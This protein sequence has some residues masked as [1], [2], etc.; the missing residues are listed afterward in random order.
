LFSVSDYARR[1]LLFEVG[2]HLFAAD[3]SEVCE[4]LEPAEA[5][6]VPGVVPGIRGLINL[7]GTLLVAGEF[8]TLLGL[9]PGPGDEPALVVFEQAGQRIALE[10]D[11]VVG[12]ASSPDGLLD[13][14][15]ELLDALDAGEM[16]RGVGRFGSRPY[17]KLD[18]K[19]VF[20][21]VLEGDGEEGDRVTRLGSREGRESE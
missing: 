2:E 6:P 4:V 20:A 11:G 18:M 14:S 21:R 12:M 7:R 1:Q 3:A 16:V 13:V 5:T 10:V 8:G 19:A 15:G 17:Y 9:K